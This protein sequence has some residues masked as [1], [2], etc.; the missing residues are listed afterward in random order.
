MTPDQR[1]PF[2]KPG[3]IKLQHLEPNTKYIVRGIIITINNK[4]FIDENLPHVAFTTKCYGT[5]LKSFVKCFTKCKVPF[6]E[7]KDDDFV[8]N[9]YNTSIRVTFK[10][11]VN[12]E[13]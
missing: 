3:I 11:K 13:M 9:S 8:S 5:I 6:E 1:K 7:I 4:T 10:S 2:N 12:D